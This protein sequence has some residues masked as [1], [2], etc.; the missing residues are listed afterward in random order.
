LSN[1]RLTQTILCPENV[2]DGTVTRKIPGPLYSLTAVQA[3]LENGSRLFICPGRPDDDVQKLGWNDEDAKALIL[4]LKTKHYRDSEWCKTSNKQW[5]P[6]DAYSIRYDDVSQ[7]EDAGYA[8][9]FVKFGFGTTN[10]HICV[11]VSCHPS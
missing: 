3:G 2:K 5:L 10:D 1:L 4:A 9:Y 7:N 11:V 6:C 8:E